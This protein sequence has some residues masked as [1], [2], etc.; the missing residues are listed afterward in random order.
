M[1]QFMTP[2]SREYE[3]L[4]R[5]RDELQ[6]QCDELLTALEAA[7]DLLVACQK[8][9]GYLPEQR[10]YSATLT[11]HEMT[12][13]RGIQSL[14]IIIHADGWHRYDMREFHQLSLDAQQKG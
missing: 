13:A 14:D 6:D 3:E 8:H 10:G 1:P 9:A 5:H 11:E 12:L 2:S 7:R 4:R